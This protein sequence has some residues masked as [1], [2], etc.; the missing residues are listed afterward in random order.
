MLFRAGTVRDTNQKKEFLGCFFSCIFLCSY[1]DYFQLSTFHDCSLRRPLAFAVSHLQDLGLGIFAGEKSCEKQFICKHSG[2][3][4]KKIN[5][6]KANINKLD[7]LDV[8]VYEEGPTWGTDTS[9][10]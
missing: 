2:K 8:T 10:E 1:K 6:H 9:A 7:F 4:K 5:H 3:K